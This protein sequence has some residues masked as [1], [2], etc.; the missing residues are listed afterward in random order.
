MKPWRQSANFLR[1]GSRRIKTKLSL[2]L[3]FFFYTAFLYSQ[4]A[5]IKLEM[6]DNLLHASLYLRDFPSEKIITALKDGFRSEI[7]FHIKVYRKVRGM[8]SLFG[9]RLVLEEHP[10]HEAR[11]DIVNGQFVIDSS[12]GDTMSFNNENSFLNAFFSL[13]NYRLKGEPL[14]EC[15][16]DYKNCYVLGNIRV[17][18]VKLIPPLTI[19]SFFLPS[20]TEGTPWKH[21]DLPDR[22]EERK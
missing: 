21:V 1:T 20:N 6:V 9:D 12:F 7:S 8:L 4:E 10:A 14:K 22:V 19:L 3:L 18:T 15:L 2:P 11:L 13:E 5:D 16:K 17:Q